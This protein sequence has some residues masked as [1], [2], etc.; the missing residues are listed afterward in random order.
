MRR[1]FRAG[2]FEGVCTLPPAARYFSQ[3]LAHR[4]SGKCLPS[5]PMRSTSLHPL[6]REKMDVSFALG[7]TGAGRLQS[8]QRSG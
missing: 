8:K 4:H 7:M 1:Y 3:H 6:A 2:G 5:T